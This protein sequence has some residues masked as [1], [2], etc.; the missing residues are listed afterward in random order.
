MK[1]KKGCRNSHVLIFI[2]CIKE[3]LA[4]TLRDSQPT[5]CYVS[6]SLAQLKIAHLLF[7]SY[8]P[9]HVSSLHIL[10]IFVDINICVGQHIFSSTKEALVPAAASYLSCLSVGSSGHPCKSV[11][12]ISSGLSGTADD[13]LYFS[14]LN[15][16]RDSQSTLASFV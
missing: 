1:L 11:V 2:S 10:E 7:A 15:Y 12:H 8:T 5:S 3:L 4:C 9:S 13:D 14:Y 6:F 16:P